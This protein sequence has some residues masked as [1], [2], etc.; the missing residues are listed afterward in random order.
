MLMLLTG[1][2]IDSA[3]ALRIGLVSRVT[4]PE[5]LLEEAAAIAAKIVANAP[6]A[7]RA[8]KRLVTHGADLPLQAAIDVERLTWGV[9]RDTEDRIEGRLAFQ[10]KR[11]PIYRGR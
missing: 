10:Q 9:L 8:V 2:P 1:E 3:E 7:V 11:K 5:V 6:L 4:A